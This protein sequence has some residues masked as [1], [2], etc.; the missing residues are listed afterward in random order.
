MYNLIGTFGKVNKDEVKHLIEDVYNYYNGIINPSNPSMGLKFTDVNISVGFMKNIC[1]LAHY[2]SIEINTNFFSTR[3]N[4]ITSIMLGRFN[5]KKANDILATL[6]IDVTLHE[7]SHLQQDFLKYAEGDLFSLFGK[8]VNVDNLEQANAWR[9]REFII[10]HQEEIR[11]KFDVDVNYALTDILILYY[12]KPK[13]DFYEITNPGDYLL[14][15]FTGFGFSDLNKEAMEK[16]K[17]SKVGVTINDRFFNVMDS[18]DVF[19][20]DSL[21][22]YSWKKYNVSI[23]NIIQLKSGEYAISATMKAVDDLDK[24]NF[25]LTEMFRYCQPV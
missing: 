12:K 23:P 25:E 18:K 22:K 15:T 19:A 21:I 5:K 8:R 17:I 3:S 16:M 13:Y 20:I 4:G 10:S 9:T 1:A 7:L 24:N 14:S 6:A 2:N 11:D